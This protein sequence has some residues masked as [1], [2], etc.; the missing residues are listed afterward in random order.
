MAVASLIELV[1]EA[2]PASATSGSTRRVAGS[3]IGRV[4][5]LWSPEP[6]VGC[7]LS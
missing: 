3:T 7:A 6:V 4:R 5:W 2:Q 1:R